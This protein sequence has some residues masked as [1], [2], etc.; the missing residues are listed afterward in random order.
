[1][2]N[3]TDL[4]KLYSA[5][6]LA[7]ATD[8]PNLGRLERPDASV[9]RRSPLC[10]SSVTVD[11]MISDGHLSAL[12]QDVK[13]CALGQAAASIT[14]QAAQGATLETVQ[15]GRDQL[16][17]MLKGKGGVPDAPFDGFEVLTPAVEYKNRHAS[18]LLSIEAL[19]E[20][21]DAATG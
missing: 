15:R 11:V 4:I 8:I 18:I 3:D 21:M 17:A 2:S 7:L 1:M 6:I 20:A 5:R 10:G 12:G 14:A 19:A 13:A 16:K 9:T